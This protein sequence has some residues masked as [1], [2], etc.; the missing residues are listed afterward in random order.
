MHTGKKRR[1]RTP[2][3]EHGWVWRTQLRPSAA[4]R[5]ISSRAFWSRM[6][7]RS[8]EMDGEERNGGGGNSLC[9]EQRNHC[10]FYT[11]FPVGPCN[12][13]ATILS[14]LGPKVNRRTQTSLAPIVCSGGLF[15]FALTWRAA[16]RLEVNES[17]VCRTGDK[18]MLG[19]IWGSDDL[20]L[21]YKVMSRPDL[22]LYWFLGSCGVGVLQ[23]ESTF[24][25][26]RCC[27][28]VK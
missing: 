1:T 11:L 3:R 22:H 27:F 16:D 10:S 19:L 14:W 5:V 6:W 25:T 15:N 28:Q 18:G 17:Q 26:F 12:K 9:I 20:L 13:E 4:L 23:N 21:R 7:K 8:N 24:L 2:P